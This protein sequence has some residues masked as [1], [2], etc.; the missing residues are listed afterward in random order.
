MVFMLLLY[1]RPHPPTHPPKKN[2][3][4]YNLLIFECAVG[5]NLQELAVSLALKCL[6]FDFMGTS[7]DES[8]EDFGSI[9]VILLG[10]FGSDSIWF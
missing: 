7:L 9:Q 10:S 1:E 2:K 3:K 5:S 4:K 8:S 6:S